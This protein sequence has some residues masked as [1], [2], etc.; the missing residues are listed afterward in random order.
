[1]SRSIEANS[2]TILSKGRATRGLLKD[3]DIAVE[4]WPPA[5]LSPIENCFCEIQIRAKIKFG[6]IMKDDEPWDYV[7]DM[8]MECY[9]KKF[10]RRCYDNVQH[11]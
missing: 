5:D 9:F 2:S 4:P 1:M 8:V 3:H 6:K 10:V 11:K 7:T